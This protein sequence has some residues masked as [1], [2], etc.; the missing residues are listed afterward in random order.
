MKNRRTPLWV[1]A[2]LAVS[3]ILAGCGIPKKTRTRAELL[4]SRTEQLETAAKSAVADIDK[5][6]EEKP[7]VAPYA[8]SENWKGKQQSV[9]DAIGTFHAKVIVPIEQMLE[10]DSRK[11][12]QL[13]DSRV[14]TAEHTLRTFSSQIA[15]SRNRADGMLKILEK[16]PSAAKMVAGFRDELAPPMQ[17]IRELEA[18]LSEKH[19]AKASRLQKQLAAIESDYQSLRS[20]A[21]NVVS[22]ADLLEK[23]GQVDLAAALD[24]STAAVASKKKLESAIPAYVSW[25]NELES[26]Y[27]KIL[28]DMRIEHYVTISRASWD[29]WSDF[30]TTRNYTYRPKRVSESQYMRLSTLNDSLHASTVGQYVPGLNP[31]ESWPGGHDEAEYWV[32]DYDIKLYHK[33]RIVSDSGEKLTDW[34]EVDEEEFS[35]YIDAL[36]MSVASKPYGYFEDEVITQPHP[37]GMAMVGDP[38]AGEWRQDSQGRSFWHYYGQY[39][40]LNALL[41]DTYGGHRYYRSDYD[42]WYRNRYDQPYY[43]SSSAG[44]RVY[45]TRGLASSSRR[46]Q[47]STFAREGYT[48]TPPRSVRA[49]ADRRGG[50]PGSGGK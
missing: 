50:G 3:V 31:R 39:A 17:S 5:I 49:G 43:G 22:Q 34:V 15:A 44:T 38:T 6:V 26:S 25:A 48:K 45:G 20:N 28:E 24:Q 18:R 12:A 9:V 11:K 29:N 10:E 19:P 37:P 13:L 42:N 7:R 4:I 41:G 14:A 1:S 35:P 8:Q 16:L 2:C 30:D 46:Y 40:M 27:T 47:N 21:E 36:G 32:E 33:Y 23:G